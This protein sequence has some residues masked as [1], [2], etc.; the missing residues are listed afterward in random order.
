MTGKPIC[1]VPRRAIKRSREFAGDIF[2]PAIIRIFLPHPL[3]RNWMILWS[4][5]SFRNKRGHVRIFLSP[6]DTA[7]LSLKIGLIIHILLS[8]SLSLRVF[9]SL[10]QFAFSYR[11]TCPFAKNHFLR[12]NIHC[13]A[14]TYC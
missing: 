1:F 4:E 9:V 12:T 14:T 13:S 11:Q 8:S 7:R 10:T 5:G 2:R 3:G 6:H